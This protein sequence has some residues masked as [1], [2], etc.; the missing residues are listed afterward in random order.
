MK[1]L[2]GMLGAML[3]I[4]TPAVGRNS[5]NGRLVCQGEYSYVGSEPAKQANQRKLDSWR[6]YALP[7]GSY[8]VE[9]EM[10]TK[11]D[12]PEI[13][14]H[15]LFTNDFQ[16][17]GF[18]FL[19]RPTTP[20][21]EGPFQLDCDYEPNQIRCRATFNGTTSAATLAQKTLYV[22]MPIAEVPVFDCPWFYQMLVGQAQRSP[23]VKT[24]VALVSLK[25]GETPDSIALQSHES[26]QVEYL[27]QEKIQ[28]LEQ[29]IVAHRFRTVHSEESQDF[30]L[31][32]SGLLLQMQMGEGKIVLSGYQGQALK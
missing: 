6:M 7:D 3:L 30:W 4:F 17:K 8:E 11:R 27:G 15:H 31:S 22:F 5:G 13:V 19:V 18:T 1:S 2:S 26:E 32:P 16:P 29:S 21:D 20:D 25:D 12:D 24:S 9:V 23:G 28:V 10:A 14:E